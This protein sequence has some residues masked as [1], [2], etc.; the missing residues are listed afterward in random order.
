MTAAA[1]PTAKRFTVVTIHPE[2]IE[3]PFAAGVV[4]RAA[5]AGLISLS[6]VNPRDFTDD[7]HRRVDDIP[8]G[9]G[10]GMVMKYQPLA[11][12]MRHLQAADAASSPPA[13]RILLSPSGTPFSQARARALTQHDHLILVCGRYEGIDQRFIDNF[14]DEEL[15]LGDYVLSGGELAAMVVIDAVARLLPG[16]L[17]DDASSDDESFSAGLLE[18]PQYTR[19]P[20]IDDLPVPEVLQSGHHGQVSAWRHE[21]AMRR[22][23]TRRPE[24]WRAFREPAAAVKKWPPG[25]RLAE[26]LYLCVATPADL[27]LGQE[28]GASFGLPASHVLLKADLAADLARLTSLHGDEPAVHELTHHDAAALAE[29]GRQAFLRPS[30]AVVL[31]LPAAS[32]ATL[33]V[34][35][36]GH[37]LGPPNP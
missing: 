8:Y 27:A 29:L 30:Q 36:L 28:I 15:S 33:A 16:V 1:S 35:A 5:T 23:A 10:P 31:T 7:K 2:M 9:G 13:R 6:A 24:L 19:P 26:R 3:S 4:G 32:F 11:A 25:L 20:L 34:L 37:L 12:T 21:Q 17:G 14:I 18:Y 22:T